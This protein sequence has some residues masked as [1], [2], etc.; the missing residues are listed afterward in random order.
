M[1][2]AQYQPPRASLPHD[3]R[4]IG[5]GVVP[6][7]NVTVMRPVHALGLADRMTIHGCRASFRTWASECTKADFAVMALS[8][9]HF[10]GTKVVRAYAR[11]ELAEKRRALMDEWGRFA[12]GELP[13]PDQGDIDGHGEPS[14]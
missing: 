10:V 1:H 8:L 7:S 9:G 5:V 3:L 13:L 11:G 4:R 14:S 6:V 12:I 2:F